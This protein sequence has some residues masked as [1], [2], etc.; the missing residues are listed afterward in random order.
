MQELGL[1]IASKGGG[2]NS[3]YKI[4]KNFAVMDISK[5]ASTR[6]APFFFALAAILESSNNPETG[7][8]A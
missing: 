4:A 1:E 2:G 7:A 6:N 8:S 5:N 3:L